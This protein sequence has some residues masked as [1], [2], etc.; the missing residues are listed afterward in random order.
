MVK[1]NVA[2]RGEALRREEPFFW[3]FGLAISRT[4]AEL[5]EALQRLRW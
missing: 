3:T 4:Q 2:L 5:G 1:S